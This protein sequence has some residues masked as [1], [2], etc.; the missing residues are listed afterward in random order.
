M[1]ALEDRN[2]SL[3]AWGAG[4]TIAARYVVVGD[5]NKRPPKSQYLDP[6]ATSCGFLGSAY[7]EFIRLRG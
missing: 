5:D 4:C 3:E 6:N 7:G 1:V 2:M